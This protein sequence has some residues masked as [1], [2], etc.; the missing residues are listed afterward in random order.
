MQYRATHFTRR[1]FYTN[2]FNTKTTITTNRFAPSTHRS[3]LSVLAGDLQE[4][5]FVA[6]QCKRNQWGRW[7]VWV[8]SLKNLQIMKR[9]YHCSWWFKFEGKII[10]FITPLSNRMKECLHGADNKVYKLSWM[11]WYFV[12]SMKTSKLWIFFGLRE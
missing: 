5:P 12:K 2:N 7:E 1:S 4:W 9:T 3:A 8:Q 11:Q 6:L 10:D